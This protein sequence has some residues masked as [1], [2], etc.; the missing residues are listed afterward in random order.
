MLAFPCLHTEMV[1]S[2]SD[3]F[4]LE[5]QLE[6]AKHMASSIEQVIS[7]VDVMLKRITQKSFE[8][9]AEIRTAADR[10]VQSVS[11]FEKKAVSQ[12]K[13]VLS[14]KQMSL[15]NQKEELLM[16]LDEVNNAVEYTNNVLNHSVVEEIEEWQ[17][18]LLKQLEELSN[19]HFES[20]ATESD[21]VEFHFF[22]EDPAMLASVCMFGCV[23]SEGRSVQAP[24]PLDSST[25]KV[26]RETRNKRKTQIPVIT[27]NGFVLDLTSDG[28]GPK[29][30]FWENGQLS[31]LCS[32]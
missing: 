5:E 31:I 21:D 16:R 7:N 23:H 30:S 17:S 11:E 29:N 10:L 25:R 8:T 13:E 20:K 27:V 22:Y 15:E 9:I 24:M 26:Q 2:A 14:L 18:A 28:N 19:L 4:E 32:E 1:L 3:R 12:V 6:E